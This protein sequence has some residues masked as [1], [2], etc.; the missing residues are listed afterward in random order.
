MKKL[1]ITDVDNT[2]Y[3]WVTFYSRA[4]RAMVVEL[5]Q[6]LGVSDEQ[7]LT[8]FQE[9]HR[10]YATTEP[11]FAALELPT[12]LARFPCLTA[13]DLINKLDP[14]FH[15]F[16]SARREHLRLYAGVEE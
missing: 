16:N 11:P 2:L 5:S 1:L 12:V 6:L 14:A 9:I 10:R 15:A 4:F 7:L 3:D 8:E 13:R